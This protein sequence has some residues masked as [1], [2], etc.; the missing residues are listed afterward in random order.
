MNEAT[1]K[2]VLRIIEKYGYQPSLQARSM[3]TRKTNI[4]AV[5]LPDVSNPFFAEVVR[6]IEQTL[7]ENHLN[8]FLMTTEEDVELENSF[9]RLAQNYNVDGMILCSPRLD[10][11]NLRKLIPEIAPVVLLNRNLDVEGATCILVDANYGGYTATKFLIEKGHSKIGIIVSPPRAFSNIQRLEG[12]KKA[13]R[14]YD[15]SLDEDLIIQVEADN[16][17]FI[18]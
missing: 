18:K 14:E 7:R 6:G 13:L 12:Y 15:I 8:I 5:L 1:R 17:E 10:E 3:V 9:I 4:V 11:A 16:T 2:Q